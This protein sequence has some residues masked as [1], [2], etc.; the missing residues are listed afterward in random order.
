MDTNVSFTQMQFIG[1]G[2]YEAISGD[3]HFRRIVGNTAIYGFAQVIFTVVLGLLF[4]AIDTR[5]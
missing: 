1:L 4:A 2:N 5:S 3:R